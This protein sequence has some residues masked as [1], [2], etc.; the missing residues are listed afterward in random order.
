MSGWLS[1]HE[2]AM[3]D[4]DQQDEAEPRWDVRAADMFLTGG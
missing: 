2:E 4:G 3:Q 1:Q